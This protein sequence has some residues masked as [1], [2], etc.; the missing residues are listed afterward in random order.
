MAKKKQ[1][2]NKST[3]KYEVCNFRHSDEVR[4]LIDELAQA[5][6]LGFTD[7][8]RQLVNA[9][10]A[11]KYG[12]RIQGNRVIDRGAAPSLMTVSRAS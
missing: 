12:V 1:T 2:P 8:M 9:G 6:S 11:S 3:I 10:L 4:E 7:V 5:E